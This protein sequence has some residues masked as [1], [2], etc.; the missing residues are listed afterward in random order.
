MAL[1]D[2]VVRW[3]GRVVEVEARCVRLRFIRP[4]FG[5]RRQQQS[6]DQHSG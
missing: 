2:I 5:Q 6:G 3:R 1:P 4:T